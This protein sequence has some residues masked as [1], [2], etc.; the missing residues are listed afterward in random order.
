MTFKRFTKLLAILLVSGCNTLSSQPTND[1]AIKQL[2]EYIQ[3]YQWQ[4]PA[5]SSKPKPLSEI[6]RLKSLSVTD[7]RKIDAST[8]EMIFEAKYESLRDVH[9]ERIGSATSLVGTSI[10]KKGLDRNVTG[11]TVKFRLYDKRGW[12]LQEE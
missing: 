9:N 6:V 2:T 4:D 7:T 11:I 5:Y 10:I 1:D 3:G 8:V 12:V